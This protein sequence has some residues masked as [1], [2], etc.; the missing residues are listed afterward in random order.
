MEAERKEK[1]E[2]QRMKRIMFVRRA[3]N[4][5]GADKADDDERKPSFDR[6][7]ILAVSASDVERSAND[8]LRAVS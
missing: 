4:I 3:I 7:C 6:R 1:G 5:D 8:G 2:N